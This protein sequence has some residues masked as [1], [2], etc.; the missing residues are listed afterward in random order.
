MPK[1][2]VSTTLEDPE[3]N[4]STV[5]RDDVAGQVAELQAA[6]TGGDILVNGSVQLVQA[7]LE[8]DLVDE[9]G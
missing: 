1:Y 3:W 5:S 4:N 7:L 8:H 6:A 9:C 2:V